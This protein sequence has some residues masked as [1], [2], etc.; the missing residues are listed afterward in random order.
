M[1][2]DIV[3][4]RMKGASSQGYGRQRPMISGRRGDCH[5]AHNHIGCNMV[6]K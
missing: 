4:P 3:T 2:F 6:E 5:E 1:F